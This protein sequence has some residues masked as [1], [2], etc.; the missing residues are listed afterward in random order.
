MDFLVN[1]VKRFQL[2][3]EGGIYLGAVCSAHVLNEG[4]AAAHP[5]S[6]PR[7]IWERI[8]AAADN[9]QSSPPKGE[10]LQIVARLTGKIRGL[11]PLG[12]CHWS[13]CKRAA[14][15]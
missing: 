8:S 4:S 5:R 11:G 9:Y 7:H 6:R 10:M 12:W 3:I 13:F 2:G 15:W 14:E 1:Q